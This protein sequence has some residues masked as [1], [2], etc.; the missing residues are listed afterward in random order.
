MR[1]EEGA[2]ETPPQYILAHGRN[3]EQQPNAAL[4]ILLKETQ[5]A[6]EWVANVFQ[7]PLWIF[8]DDTAQLKECLEENYSLGIFPHNFRFCRSECQ[9]FLL[10]HDS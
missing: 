9:P 6:S 5:E 10:L 4:P 3:S 8:L 1:P 7:L 2:L